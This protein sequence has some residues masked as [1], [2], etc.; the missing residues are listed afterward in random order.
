[1][2]TNSYDAGSALTSYYP[3]RTTRA[4]ARLWSTEKLAADIDALAPG[5]VFE[6]AGSNP[7]LLSGYGS[8]K[9]WLRT[10]PGV[11][12]AAAEFRSWNGSSP[13]S[14]LVNWPVLTW[15][16]FRSM[17]VAGSTAGKLDASVSAVKALL[18]YTPTA[19]RPKP[20]V[21]FF[22]DSI[23]AASVNQDTA[24][25]SAMCNRGAQF[26][27]PFL[28]RKRIVSPK[29][30]NFGVSGNT[31]SQ[32]LARV[33]D[34][35]NAAPGV[36]VVHGGTNDGGTAAET[37]ANLAAIY[38]EL[39]N[40][41]ITVVA[42]PILPRLVTSGDLLQRIATVNRWLRLS[43]TARANFY[44]ADSDATFG[45]KF[46]TNGQPP[47]NYTYDNLHPMALGAYYLSVPIA[48]IIERIFPE[49]PSLLPAVWDGTSA[50]YGNRTFNP[51][52]SGSGGTVPVG[53][54]GSIADGWTGSLAAGGGSLPTIVA[55]K[56]FPV[57][58]Q[59]PPYT[60]MQQLSFSG[61]VSG[62]W[63]TVASIVQV[64]GFTPGEKLEA[65][66][67]IECEGLSQV[68]GVDLSLAAIGGT[69]LEVVDGFPI[70]SDLVPSDVFSGRL[71]TPP[72]QTIAGNTDVYLNVRVWW[73]NTAGTAA[74]TVR[75]GDVICR[76]VY[77]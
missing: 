54:S 66:C 36:C 76:K 1:M 37:I 72:L 26:W 33:A 20:V 51:F 27:V 22:G 67:E 73:K 30:M 60:E 59:R 17:I 35:I 57:Y 40:A 46:A 29:E 14:D 70:V 65:A 56:V 74:G 23:T 9:V 55:S 34:V 69:T 16:N 62:G 8:A 32:M 64:I 52:M 3:D 41:G 6:G 5:F 77:P 50:P 24:T 58:G 7:T 44:V 61:A 42:V 11:T 39:L 45:D 71:H 12:S 28:T 10:D 63:G 19:G 21:A 4:V 53:M 13:V 2:T 68:S 18:G 75:I 15:D 43:A 38:D 49:P 31:T 48:N 47:A 25:F